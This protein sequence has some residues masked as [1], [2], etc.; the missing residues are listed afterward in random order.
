MPR[1]LLLLL[2]AALPMAA[3]QGRGSIAGTAT[4]HRAASTNYP[5]ARDPRIIEF[6]LRMVF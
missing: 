6:G 3:Q 2:L 4:D 1:F 5:S